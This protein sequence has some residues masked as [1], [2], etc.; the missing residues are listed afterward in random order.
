MGACNAKANKPGSIGETAPNGETIIQH[1]SEVPTP[2]PVFHSDK[3]IVIDGVEMGDGKVAHLEDPKT[4][5]VKKGKLFPAVGGGKKKKDAW[6]DSPG[7]GF[8]KIDGPP[9]SK[10][11]DDKAIAPAEGGG[12]PKKKTMISRLL[13]GGNRSDNKDGDDTGNGSGGGFLG[14]MFGHTNHADEHLEGAG[15]LKKYRSYTLGYHGAKNKDDEPEGKGV[16]K[17]PDGSVYDGE[18]HNGRRHGNGVYTF[19]NGDV[20]KGGWEEG[21]KSGEGVMKWRNGDIYEGQ[22]AMNKRHGVG[23]FKGHDGR[24]YKGSYHDDYRHG[25]GVYKDLRGDIY[26]GNWAF[27]R[28]SR[29]GIIKYANYDVFQGEF[30]NDKKHGPGTWFFDIGMKFR[31]PHKFPFDWTL[32]VNKVELSDLVHTA[33]HMALNSSKRQVLNNPWVRLNIGKGIPNLGHNTTVVMGYHPFRTSAKKDQSRP[34]WDRDELEK[35]VFDIEDGNLEEG[36]S[37]K[38]FDEIT[39][40]N[41]ELIGETVVNLKKLESHIGEDIELP[42]SFLFHKGTNSQ[43]DSVQQAGRVKL[44]VRMTP[45][46][47]HDLKGVASFSGEFMDDH[48]I[49]HGKYTDKDSY[50]SDAWF[51]EGGKCIRVVKKKKPIN[52]NELGYAGADTGVA[53]SG[54]AAYAVNAKSGN[55]HD[56]LFHNTHNQKM[57]HDEMHEHMRENGIETDKDFKPEDLMKALVTAKSR[58]RFPVKLQELGLHENVISVTNYTGS[59]QGYTTLKDDKGKEIKVFNGQG[60]YRY[61]DGDVYVGSFKNSKRDG[62]GEYTYAN[63][64][65]F[66]G[67]WAKDYR[68][69]YGTMKFKNGDHYEG[70]WKFNRRHGRG[71]FSSRRGNFIY[72]GYYVDDKKNGYGVLQYAN[73]DFYQGNFKSNLKHGYGVLKYANGDLYNGYFWKNKRQGRGKYIRPGPRKYVPLKP[74]TIVYSSSQDT[75]QGRECVANLGNDGKEDWNKFYSGNGADQCIITLTMHPSQKIRRY[76]VG[77]SN[78][79]FERSP[80]AWEV[81]GLVKDGKRMEILHKVDNEKFTKAWETKSYEL[82]EATGIDYRM[83]EFRC[84]AVKRSGAGLQLGKLSLET[85]VEGEYFDGEFVDDLPNGWGIYNYEDGNIV[86]GM[87]ENGIPYFEDDAVMCGEGG[88]FSPHAMIYALT[89]T[90]DLN[91]MGLEV[92]ECCQELAAGVKEIWDHFLMMT[93]EFGNEEVSTSSH[94]RRYVSHPSTDDQGFASQSTTV[95]NSPEQ[96]AEPE[97]PSPRTVTQTPTTGG[98]EKKMMKIV[99]KPK[100]AITEKPM[101]MTASSEGVHVQAAPNM[102]AAAAEPPNLRDS[103]AVAA[104][105]GVVDGVGLK[106]PNSSASLRSEEDG[107]IVVNNDEDLS[108]SY[109]V[110]H[111][112]HLA[113]SKADENGYRHDVEDEEN[114]YC[115]LDFLFVMLRMKEPKKKYYLRGTLDFTPRKLGV[116]SNQKADSQDVPPADADVE[117]LTMPE[118][119]VREATPQKTFG[120]LFAF[121]KSKK[122]KEAKVVVSESNGDSGMVAPLM[123]ARAA[124]APPAPPAT[125]SRPVGNSTLALFN[126]KFAAGQSAG[127]PPPVDNHH[128]LHLQRDH[129]KPSPYEP[130]PIGVVVG[131]RDEVLSSRSSKDENAKG[132]FDWTFGM[133]SGE[134]TKTEPSSS[135]SRKETTESDSGSMRQPPSAASAAA[136][137]PSSSAVSYPKDDVST[138]TSQK[139]SNHSFAR[140]KDASQRNIQMYKP[141]KDGRTPNNHQQSS[142]TQTKDGATTPSGWWF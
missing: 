63:G 21:Y 131:S 101:M 10:S 96:V 30:E 91:E 20:Y 23:H 123:P 15:I 88:L 26:D 60:T 58:T 103:T 100:A 43:A 92:P 36:L 134:E 141:T 127:A 110:N 109:Y 61:P 108:P 136:S 49:G 9:E 13:G 62:I 117:M 1:G 28:R 105:N 29:S 81:W 55:K 98:V 89:E 17:Y 142:N 3:S 16:Y 67:N 71:K 107:L 54:V 45:Y 119:P 97:G 80:I 93:N 38:V 79:N 44:S 78:D 25:A 11:D 5:E 116:W 106:Q 14:S 135:F 140:K 59:K 56:L 74:G 12:G 64:D 139:R 50:V 77:V 82:P 57:S 90:P 68:N 104:A 75:H 118:V 70:N 76:T 94:P 125:A 85:L 114:D 47:L 8:Q 121:S 42:V 86:E 27:N 128:I 113:L 138:S 87:F 133:M 84:A 53:Y 7:S 52:V 111:G 4:K 32:A 39:P 18:W 24:D 31:D 130:E 99:P 2:R 40:A 112:L 46:L 132:G 35:C 69:G 33:F 83:I 122:A 72:N 115:F 48:E 102:V 6:E 51:D 65:K 124:A 95:R 41:N 22:W 66:T 37:I 19:C 73:G 120:S 34:V 126:R 137:P 129:N